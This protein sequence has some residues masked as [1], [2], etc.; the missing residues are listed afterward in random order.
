MLNRQSF[1][2]RNYLTVEELQFLIEAED[3]LYKDVSIPEYM[4][5]LTD[6]AEQPLVEVNQEEFK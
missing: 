6:T 3:E 2:S 5:D 4:E 1:N